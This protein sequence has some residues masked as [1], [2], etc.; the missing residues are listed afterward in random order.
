MDPAAIIVVVFFIVV[1][2]VD[3]A[4][5]LSRVLRDLGDAVPEGWEDRVHDL[6]LSEYNRCRYVCV[7]RYF[8]VFVGLLC[9]FGAR[10]TQSARKMNLSS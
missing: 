8:C 5:A 6:L 3:L 2:F 10:D 4:A 9:D 1:V 7:V